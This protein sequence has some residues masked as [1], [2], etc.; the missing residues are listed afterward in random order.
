MGK[1][2][3]T[4]QQVTDYIVFAADELTRLRELNAKLLAACEAARAALETC[5]PWTEI[6]PSGQGGDELGMKF[7]ESLVEA[8]KVATD[9]A[10]ALVKET[11]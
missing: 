1:L 2:Q 7:D 8:A 9:A 3:F 5:D 10:I 11:Q 6:G 4:R